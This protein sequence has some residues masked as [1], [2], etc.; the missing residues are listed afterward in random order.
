[1]SIRDSATRF[2][3][4]KISPSDFGP[5]ESVHT[6]EE[7]AHEEI[8]SENRS[9][10]ARDSS[11]L[12]SDLLGHLEEEAA[13]SPGPTQKSSTT[14]SFCPSTYYSI[15]EE[16]ESETEIDS[17]LR[18]SDH[19]PVTPEESPPLEVNTPG[20]TLSQSYK[21]LVEEFPVDDSPKTVI[22]QKDSIDTQS[23]DSFVFD[24]GIE[25]DPPATPKRK[26]RKNSPA[27]PVLSPSFLGPFPTPFSHRRFIASS[28]SGSLRSRSSPSVPDLTSPSPKGRLSLRKRD[29]GRSRLHLSDI[30]KQRQAS[31][32]H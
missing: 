25:A 18:E 15:E 30:F 24:A 26:Q 6:E 7:L 29:S 27:A 22:G 21:E 19:L 9:D 17:F 5:H 10:L 11:A 13:L 23:V 2:Q 12:I 16:T 28:S 31:N 4:P 8:E 20:C 3:L 14:S 1:M 32:R